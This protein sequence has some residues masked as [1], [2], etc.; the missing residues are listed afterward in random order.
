MTDNSEQACVVCRQV[1]GDTKLVAFRLRLLYN[2]NTHMD[3]HT[4]THTHVHI[5]IFNDQSPGKCGL[6]GWPLMMTGDC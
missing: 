5:H 4:H 1:S 2:E 6:V 3:K